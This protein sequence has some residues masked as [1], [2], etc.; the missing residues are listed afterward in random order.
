MIQFAICD[1]ELAI[2]A[3]LEQIITDIL[4]DLKIEHEIDVLFSPEELEKQ[5][6][7]G[8]SYDFMFL[9][10]EYLNS[11]KNGVGFAKLIREDFENN[12]VTIVFISRESKYAL[13]LFQVQ[14][15]DFLIKPLRKEKIE[16]VIRKYLALS[17]LLKKELSYKKGR[18]T[19]KVQLKDIV[20]LESVGRKLYLHVADGTEIEFN[21]VLKEVYENQLR[22]YDFLFIHAS[23]VVNYEH[24]SKLTFTHAKLMKNGLELPI[25][26]HR[27]EE[28]RATYQKIFKRRTL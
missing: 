1:D 7:D 23:Y 16:K 28:V 11:H 6:R 10:I 25:S 12:Q 27:Q 20:Y 24:I 13:E 19:F 2:G 21:G 15:L 18:E 26:K 9:D 3:E 17:E 8:V 4:T 22:A 14:P 5:M